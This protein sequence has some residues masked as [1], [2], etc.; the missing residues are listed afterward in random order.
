MAAPNQEIDFQPL[1]QPRAMSHKEMEGYT[2]VFLIKAR[3]NKDMLKTNLRKRKLEYKAL[4]EVY[5]EIIDIN[6][7]NV[8]VM[9]ES[10]KMMI[11]MQKFVHN[12]DDT[13]IEPMGILNDITDLTDD[14]DVENNHPNEE[15]ED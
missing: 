11:K 13:V 2:R 12:A 1:E 9:R 4:E 14:G 7:E 6:N 5:G 15:E 8:R 10:Q 3:N